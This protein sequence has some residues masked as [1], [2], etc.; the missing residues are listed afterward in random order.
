V[1]PRQENHALRKLHD[2]TRRFK[3][4]IR[5]SAKLLWE[6]DRAN[7]VLV[8]MMSFVVA[9]LAPLSVVVMARV[10]SLVKS[11][12]ADNSLAVAD[13]WPWFLLIGGIALLATSA[14]EVRKYCNAR[15]TERVGLRA[16]RIVLTHSSQLNLASLEQSETQNE[17]ASVALEPGSV[18]VKSVTGLIDLIASIV[19]IS[20]LAAIM[21]YIQPL[22]TAG[23]LAA[24]L[25][26][27]ASGGLLSLARHRLRIKNAE[28]HRWS[29]YYGR[30][31]LNHKLA[32]SV[33]VLG[34]ADLMIDRDADR[35]GELHLARR[36]IDRFE[37]AV[38]LTTTMLSLGIIFFAIQ[39]VISSAALG[40]IQFYNFLAFWGAAWRLAKDSPKAAA[41][42]SAA[43]K[44]WLAIDHL[45]QFLQVNQSKKSQPLRMPEPFR[46][47]IVVDRV[48][49]RYSN[50]QR[51]A[52][53][54]VSL[55]IEPGETIAIVGHNGAGKTTLA[56]LIAG[57]YTA[58]SG[59][60]RYD[61]V[62]HTSVDFQQIYHKMAV[63]FQRSSRFEAT[64]RENIALGDW[65]RLAG[66]PAEVERVAAQLGVEEMIRSLP[67]GFETSL[68]RMFGEH[69]LSGG[70]WQ[71]LAI[72][73][74]LACDPAIVLLDEPT[75]GLDVFAEADLQ[76][77]MK[78][79]ICNRTAIIISHRFSTVM[80]ADRIIVLDK[81]RLAEQGTHLEML[82]RGGIYSAMWHAQR[83]QAA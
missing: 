78:Q 24:S 48:S 18:I 19:R 53:E 71:K 6:T 65:E 41:L 16:R 20:G 40:T 66:D 38:K 52:L 10:V 77:C 47:E 46:G 27:V 59:E 31:L 13:F 83:N 80:D 45:H 82:A 76:R 28:I 57:L 62:P 42:F 54:N 9:V 7:T 4:V 23:I 17:I 61:G 22:W 72:A 56:K 21:L 25:P 49:F 73:R 44:A 29:R 58:T 1:R 79:L 3:K 68:G 55:H 34:L 32:P 43:T 30:H 50:A 15:L 63:V 8:T 12:L 11:G 36:K 14:V 67:K 51:D 69:E 81:G 2:S 39:S 33:R 37:L 75:A 26:L 74:A 5:W 35:H 64:A 70:Q 60:V